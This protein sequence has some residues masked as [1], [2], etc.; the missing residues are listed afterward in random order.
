PSLDW[1][2]LNIFDKLHRFLPVGFYYKRFHKPRWMW[3]LFEHVVRHVA[4]L[5]KVD[6]RHASQ[7]DAGIEH[8]HTDV[9][10][11]GGGRAG[12]QAANEARGTGAHVVL[13]ERMPR[14]GGRSLVQDAQL[15]SGEESKLLSEPP[16]TV[17]FNTTAFGLYEGNLI[18]ACSDNRF[19]KIRA[20]QIIV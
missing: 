19:L 13:L 20:N 3:P 12:I 18:G 8:L 2:V 4:G 11:I 10:V 1:D 14:L 17:H 5:G 15:A 9:C 6:T 16:V 7:I